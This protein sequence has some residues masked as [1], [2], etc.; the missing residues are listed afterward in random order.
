M[1]PATFSTIPLKDKIPLI[2]FKEFTQRLPTE[3]EKKTWQILYPQCQTGVVCGPVSGLFV[4]DDD[5]GLAASGY[6]EPV[7][8]TVRT[9][10]GGRHY[11]FKWTPELDG[12]ITTKV[13]LLDKVDVRG[14]GGYVVFYGWE[15]Q[16]GEIA[17]PPRWLIDLL[18]NRGVVQRVVRQDGWLIEDLE[19]IQPGNGTHGRTPTFVRAIGRLKSKGLSMA[20][21]CGL[22]QPWAEKYECSGLAE[23][24]E[25][26]FKRYPPPGSLDGD[27]SLI[28][29]VEDYTPKP[30]IVEN[31][32]AENTINLLVGLPES[33][34]SWALLDLAISLAGGLSWMGRF[35]CEKRK[36]MVIDQE[37]PKN[38]M[39][40]RI[41]ALI[42]GRGMT[43]EQ[44]EGSLIPLAGTTI[45][46]DLQMS[47]EK[48]YL[49][50]EKE[51]PD[52][53]LV[54]SFKAFQ[55]KDITSNVAMQEVM[56]RI[57]D[58]RTKLGITF[59]F[60]F[61]ENKNAYERNREHREISNE[62]VAGA[63]VLSEVPEGIM[64]VS[65]LDEDTSIVYHTKN[66]YGT[67]IAPVT[68]K[69]IDANEEKTAIKVEAF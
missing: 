11:Y 38:E 29:F 54:D 51:R 9:P 8:W 56:E 35:P 43:V 36:V 13:G 40:K 21:I 18:P 63:A 22:L 16:E 7:T 2:E 50:L 60:I 20:E 19:N 4:L 48:F 67:K 14:Q 12:K 61:H 57:K 42:A 69:V 30:W 53:V 64:I 17:E 47:Y 1:I 34:K 68:Y 15:K 23:L 58:I 41:K 10:R 33:R 55:T 65:K 46:I 27:S 32:I 45:K 44:F 25:D 52:V 62:Y 26:Q 49:R 24:V 59:V 31:L 66:S 5:G 6:P 28:K 3:E 37:R 39:Q